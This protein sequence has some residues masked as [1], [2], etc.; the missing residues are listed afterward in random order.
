VCVCE[1]VLAGLGFELKALHLQS[2]YFIG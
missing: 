2:S 1:C